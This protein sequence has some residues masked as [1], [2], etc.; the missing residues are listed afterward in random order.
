MARD[1]VTRITSTD[2]DPIAAELRKLYDDAAKEPLP[3]ELTRLLDE[4][5][6]A[7]RRG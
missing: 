5:D 6:A 3:D 2:S 7:E 4:L 1:G